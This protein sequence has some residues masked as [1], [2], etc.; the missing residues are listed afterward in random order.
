[1][2][3][4]GIPIFGLLGIQSEL[5]SQGIS[6]SID[7]Y[8][9]WGFIALAILLYIS[10][11][12][13]GSEVAFFSI[14]KNQQ[15]DLEK[16]EGNAQSILSFLER[17]RRLL[18]TIL[19]T[20]NLVNISIIILSYFVIDAA[21]DFHGVLWLENLFEIGLVTFL[22]VLFGEIIPKV[23]ATQNNIGMAKRMAGPLKVIH[24][25]SSPLVTLLINSSGLLEK[26]LS[27]FNS[28]LTSD[29]IDQAID[30][31]IDQE[32]DSRNNKILKSI[33]KFGNITVKQIMQTRVDVVALSS[34]LDYERVVA[35]IKD[36]GYSRIPV[37]END[38]D[39]IMGILYVKDL[40]PHIEEKPDFEW[41]KLMR[42]P[43][44]VPEN[45][46]ISDL[47]EEFRQKRI[48]LAIV[49][50]EYGGTS[51]VVT[52]EDILEEV[53]GEM[54]D[55]N[56]DLNEIDYKKIDETT[57]LFEGK[58]LLNDV[59]KVID[60]SVTDF[61][62]VKGEADSLAGLILELTGY[63][64]KSGEIIRYSNYEM[65]IV[66]VNNIRIVRVQLKVLPE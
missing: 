66:T 25:L 51:G 49:V 52:M 28:N 46:K 12:I 53:M 14:D 3:D 37:F 1:M 23:Y 57:F 13:S 27:K 63:I 34:N 32:E 26:R 17:P 42:P 10:A 44:Y 19:I 22:L 6:F 40:L 20:N 59:C 18:A 55:E 8:V 43:I 2:D 62:E 35:V 5:L 39:N 48:H 38:F 56:D 29:E 41:T 11:M 30:L 4:D 54:T 64:P 7:S 9:I 50:D 61:D 21:F 58:T 15:K 65:K 16:Q 45:K 60:V 36:S 33:V 31:A 47:L 24:N